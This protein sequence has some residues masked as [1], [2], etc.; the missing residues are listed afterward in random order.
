MPIDLPHWPSLLLF[1]ALILAA[2]MFV[3]TAAG[4]FPAEHRSPILRTP[5][6]RA[7]LWTSIATV[8]LATATSVVA[9]WSRL[10][11]YAMIITAG[12]AILVAPLCLQALTDDIV[13]GR[14]GLIALAAITSAVAALSWLA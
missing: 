12:F 14:L 6:G 8:A 10:P 3:L 9:V 2:A 4:H 7:L 13:D 5:A 11:L 1:S